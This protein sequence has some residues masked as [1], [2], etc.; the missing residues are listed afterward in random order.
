M[1]MKTWRIFP[2]AE[3]ELDID[4]VRT[5]LVLGYFHFD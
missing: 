3:S 5:S 1:D 4:T 2:I